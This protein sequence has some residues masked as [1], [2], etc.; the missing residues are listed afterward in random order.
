M[1]LISRTLLLLLV[2][3]M[4]SVS[5]ASAAEYVGVREANLY[6]F[7]QHFTWQEFDRDG[8]RFLKESGSQYGMGGDLKLNLLQGGAG[9]LTLKGKQELFGGVVNYDGQLQDG[10]PHSTDVTYLGTLSEIDLGWAIPYRNITVEPFSGISYRWWQR[11]LQGSGGYTEQWHS[12]SALLGARSQYEL[13]KE[14]R[15][16]VTGAAK[17][18]FSNRNSID[19]YPGVGDIRL[20]PESEWSV[21]AEGG[22]KYRQ[23]IA[24]V[25]YEN[26]IFPESRPVTRY[27]AYRTPTAGPSN[28]IQPRSESEIVGIRIGW[29]F[30]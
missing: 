11:D 4:F 3:T 14:T 16:F 25:Y 23:L 9:A 18:P 10:T 1:N 30:R 8:S 13:A 15:F 24:S 17:Y 7:I 20:S 27:N 19:N 2:V 6:S 29:A 5:A 21:I 22:I 12:V 28:F 26:F